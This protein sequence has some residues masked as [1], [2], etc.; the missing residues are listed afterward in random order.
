MHQQRSDVR[1]AARRCAVLALVV[2][3]AA[4]LAQARTTAAAEVARLDV[5]GPTVVAYFVIPPNAV[6]TSAD[7]AVA[8]DDWSYAMA[9]LGDSLR[10]RGIALALITEPRL[11]IA[12]RGTA[13]VTIALGA[14]PA[15]GY[16]YARPGARPCL[17]R[18]WADPDSVLATARAILMTTPADT[19]SCE[20]LH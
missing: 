20:P 12:S 10:A 17:R 5:T 11:R 7:L 2:A 4:A 3:P 19:T 9:A 13:P 15:A 16:V 14:T 18:G 6:D 8:A 1:V